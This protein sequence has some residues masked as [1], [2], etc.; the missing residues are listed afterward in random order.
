LT[1]SLVSCPLLP[2]RTTSA[3][4]GDSYHVYSSSPLPASDRVQ[5]V[6]YSESNVETDAVA[7]QLE[8][9]MADLELETDATTRE[10]ETDAA[11]LELEIDVPQETSKQG[12][13]LADSEWSMSKQL[14]MGQYQ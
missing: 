5:G 11:G 8:T 10:S 12:R 2:W 6:G 14:L 9:S 3:A 4:T 13:Y 7:L 1:L